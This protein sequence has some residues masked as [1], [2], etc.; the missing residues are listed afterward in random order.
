[1]GHPRLCRQGFPGFRGTPSTR[2]WTGI[3]WAKLVA[4]GEITRVEFFQTPQTQIA[5]VRLGGQ[6][7]RDDAAMVSC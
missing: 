2:V 1:M 6:N 7:V 4:F 3:V 5:W